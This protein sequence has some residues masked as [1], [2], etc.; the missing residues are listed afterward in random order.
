M[1]VMSIEQ[2]LTTRYFE[3]LMGEGT[4][5]KAATLKKIQEYLLAYGTKE[6]I[7]SA[8]DILLDI[9]KMVSWVDANLDEINAL[10]ADEE[11]ADHQAEVHELRTEVA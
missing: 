4:D 1:V 2:K 9:P 3:L 11:E 7:R 6:Q 8:V 5:A 10:I